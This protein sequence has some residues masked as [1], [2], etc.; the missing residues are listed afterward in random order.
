M[1]YSK[2]IIKQ[3]DY[4]MDGHIYEHIISNEV[5]RF[6]MKNGAIPVIDF[7]IYAHTLDGIVIIMIETNNKNL[8]KNIL[9]HIEEYAINQNI[10][11]ETI[12]QISAEYERTYKVDLVK[13]TDKLNQI[14]KT[15]WSD[16]QNDLYFTKPITDIAR[17]FNSKEIQYLRRRPSSFDNIQ[18]IYKLH[19][20]PFEVKPLAVY[21]LQLIAL[22]H[23]N[24]LYQKL[25]YCYDSGDEW[26]KYQDMVGY[27]HNLRIH[28]KYKTTNDIL[29]QLFSES[30]QYLLVNN[31]N[32]K[33]INYIKHESKLNSS[34]FTMENIFAFAYTIPGRKGLAKIANKKNIEYILN[35]LVVTV[36]RC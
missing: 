35:N 10:V 11:S 36:E 20:C 7:E 31:F 19:D 3:T 27:L 1:K 22:T 28:K 5:S 23:I 32:S 34:Y 25:E 24:L 2:A 15:P 6:L 4:H 18:F 9:S 8:I 21:I 16:R 33:L 17:G 12:E 29:L 26:A 30:K 13:L 14:H